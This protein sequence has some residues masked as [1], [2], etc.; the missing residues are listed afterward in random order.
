MLSF[1]EREHFVQ[2]DYVIVGSGIV[3][4]STA[5]SIK[6]ADKQASVLVLERGLL[7]TGAS[8]RN[9]GFACFGSLTEL[10]A[11]V[12]TMGAE[13]TVALVLNR[14][15]GLEKLRKRLGDQTLDFKNYGGYE[16]I[17]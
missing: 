7:P 17:S 11:D 1:W 10:I 3:G 16:L 4:L 15:S 8:T 13:E 6:E 14:W 12:N 5:V 9:A 2:Y